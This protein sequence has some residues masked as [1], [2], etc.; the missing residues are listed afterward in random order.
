[1]TQTLRLTM[2]RIPS[3]TRLYMEMGSVFAKQL[4]NGGTF[5]V[6][7]YEPSEGRIKA[8]TASLRPEGRGPVVHL[9]T[10]HGTYDLAATQR[11]RLRDGR[12]AALDE[13]KPGDEI[14]SCDIQNADG[15]IFIDTGKGLAALHD[16]I[17]SDMQGIAATLGVPQPSTYQPGVVQK[18][19]SV[20]PGNEGD[21]CLLSV[22]EP[23]AEAEGH[24]YMLW[25]DGTS[26]G[27]GI[28]VY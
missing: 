2:A 7:S 12:A 20:T 1:M 10:T 16:L 23:T 28:F 24:C 6:L 11:V 21:L 27:S 17:E 4:Q 25:P 18:V 19:V 8:K 26:F 22:D 14:H 5:V 9:K 13:L 15:F 3:T